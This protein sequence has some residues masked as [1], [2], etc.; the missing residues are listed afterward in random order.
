VPGGWVADVL[1]DAPKDV[2]GLL[3]SDKVKV[4]RAERAAKLLAGAKKRLADRGIEAE[5]PSLKLAI[6]ILAAAADENRDELRDLWERLLAAA[7]DPNRQGAFRQ[8]FITIVKEM[9]PFDALV[10]FSRPSSITAALNGSRMHVMQ[11]Q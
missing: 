1:G 4:L 9:D 10:L 6:P 7:M 8:N 2:V 3:F 11:F 5:P